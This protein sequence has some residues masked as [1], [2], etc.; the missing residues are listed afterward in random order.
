MTLLTPPPS[1]VMHTCH[2][3]HALGFGDVEMDSAGP[4]RCAKCHSTVPHVQLDDIEYRRARAR[5]RNQ[6]AN[7]KNSH[8]GWVEH[9]LKSGRPESVIRH[10]ALLTA[11][12]WDDARARDAVC[13]HYAGMLAKY[14]IGRW[15][16]EARTKGWTAEGLSSDYAEKI[17]QRAEAEYVSKDESKRPWKYLQIRPEARAA[18][19]RFNTAL[20]GARNTGE[21]VPN[22][23]GK[24][25]LYSDYT[26]DDMPTGDEAFDLC[27]GCPLLGM[28][29]TFA[30]LERPAWGVWAGDRWNM[31]ETVND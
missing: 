8:L 3:G 5:K 6:R 28:C 11:D 30:E 1:R 15:P 12:S 10:A 22:C 17:M 21:S 20:E 31:G 19:D 2:N 25:G 13:L 29:A 16:K 27:Y 23:D 26:E 7:R 9:T 24:P 4:V 14:R 18:W